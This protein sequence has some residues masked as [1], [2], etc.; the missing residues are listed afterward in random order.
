VSPPEKEKKSQ[1]PTDEKR[2]IP[3]RKE[4]ITMSATRE[5]KEKAKKEEKRVPKSVEKTKSDANQI[6]RFSLN[7]NTSFIGIN[8]LSKLLMNVDVKAASSIRYVDVTIYVKNLENQM[9]YLL[10]RF[11]MYPISRTRSF[12]FLWQYP[13]IPFG[14][15]KPY[16]IARFYDKNRKLINEDFQFWGNSSSPKIYILFKN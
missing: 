5:Q 1:Y 14:K 13:N 10:K 16:V 8:A 4:K 15:Y 2:K 7:N 11:A 9:V 6:I 12:S 3:L